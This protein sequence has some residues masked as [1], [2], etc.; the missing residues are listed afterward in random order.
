VVPNHLVEQFAREFLQLYPNAR[1]L[2]AA[3]EGLARDR[4]K[5]LTAKIASGQRDGIVVTHSS[6]KPNA[7]TNKTTKKAHLVRMQPA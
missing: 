3:K 7:A 2:V 6:F 4:C 5:L 1:L